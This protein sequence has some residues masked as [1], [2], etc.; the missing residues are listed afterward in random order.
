MAQPLWKM[1]WWFLIKLNIL[2][3]YNP[4]TAL[5]GNLNKGDEKLCPQ[6]NLPMDV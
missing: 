3:P 1:A 2:L 4:A 5:L 6:K